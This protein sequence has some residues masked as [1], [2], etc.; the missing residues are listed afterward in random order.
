MKTL[1]KGPF[2]GINTRRSDFSLKVKDAGDYV[3][4]A[5]NVILNDSGNFIS[6]QAGEIVQSMSDP[7]SLFLI[8]SESGF[9]VRGGTIYAITLPSYS[10]T[11]LKILSNNDPVHWLAENGD[12]YYSNGTDSGRIRSGLAY[13]IGLPAP[14]A[15]AIASIPGGDLLAGSYKVMLAYANNVTGE[16]GA[17]SPAGR[18]ELAAT[19]G[20]RVTIPAATAGATHVLIYCSAANGSSCFLAGSVEIGV[21]SVFDISVAASGQDAIERF[22]APLPPGKLF[23]FNGCL[24]SY[25]DG[26]VFEGIP[27]RPGYYLPAEGRIPF[28]ADVSNVI[29][30][31]NGIYIIAD[32]TYWIPGA[33]ITTGEGV[34]QEVLPYGGV[35]HTEF[36]M[37]GEAGY[38]WFG[39]SGIVVASPSGE[40]KAVMDEV[41]AGIDTA[42]GFS[43][44]ASM[45]G[46][47]FVVSCNWC[48]NLTTKAI[49]RFDDAYTSVSLGYGTRSDGLYRIDA[50]KPAEWEI[51]LGKDNFGTDAEKTMPAVYVGAKSGNPVSL[52]IQ[53]PEDDYTYS[54]R[55]CSDQLK[56]HRIDPG[57]GLIA[58][59]FDLTLQGDSDLTLATVEFAVVASTRR[60]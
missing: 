32:K 59:W 44:S 40:V 25:K 52:R 50:G 8:D 22:E 43:Y 60:I 37:P 24:C 49:T 10:E 26:D 30:A 58:N 17:L 20:I 4:D 51:A 21:A 47:Q 54:A 55:S 34:I 42:S 6:R 23:M 28:P 15:P 3:R 38:G 53:T 46:A 19:G 33:R 9:L 18:V 5:V 56:I 16:V 29:P 27:F 13:P 41:I 48:L 39:D 7:H 45:A 36:Q 14:D 57:K 12:V 2:L 31:Q 1:P 11:M 35:S